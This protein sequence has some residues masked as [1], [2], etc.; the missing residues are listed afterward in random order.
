[1]RRTGIR[2]SFMPI[3]LTTILCLAPVALA[4][5]S[6]HSISPD[7]VT[8]HAQGEKSR[9]VLTLSGPGGLVVHAFGPGERPTLDVFDAGGQ[10][11]PDSSYTWELKSEPMSKGSERDRHH[12]EVERSTLPQ[13]IFQ[14]GYVTVDN[15]RFVMPD[16]PESTATTFGTPEVEQVGTEAVG[17]KDFVVQ[18]EFI[19]NG[20]A[21][22]GQDCTD[23]EEFLQLETLRLKEDH[24][25]LE[26]QDTSVGVGFPSNDWQI[27]VNDAGSGGANRFSIDD[28]DAA[29]VPFTLEAGAPDHS[30]Y[31][32]D[33]GHLG[34]GTSTPAADIHRVDGDTP[35]LRL[36]QD[37]S[38]GLTPQ[39]WDVGGNENEFFV[40]DVTAGTTPFRIESNGDAIFSGSGIRVD[41]E[42]STTGVTWFLQSDS[43]SDTLL[44][45]KFG[46]GGGEIRIDDRQDGGTSGVTFFVDGSIQATN[47]TFSSARDKKQNFESVET[48]DVLER[49]HGLDIQTWQYKTD[50]RGTRHMGPV[51][52]DFAAAFGLGRSDEHITM[53]DINGVALASIQA[54]Y[55]HLRELRSENADLRGYVEQ[56]EERLDAVEGR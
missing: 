36:E 19:V 42:D 25:R 7:R 32:D 1:M 53:V 5:S 44:I 24:L 41:L 55:D 35:T 18:D 54:L 29:T 9:L 12:S 3:F 8:W 31:V 34:L 27:T 30:L 13:H 43:A 4:E 21:C 38:A 50:T 2:K 37:G 45:S 49:L 51:A 46:S 6:T 28:I 40:S 39:T 10:P 33:A 11:L 47:V 17:E 56:L 15:G 20:S 14:S 23:G 22:I 52:E 16:M 26:F 48:T